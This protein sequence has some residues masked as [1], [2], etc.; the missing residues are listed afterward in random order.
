MV[1][2]ALVVLATGCSD[3][4][5]VAPQACEQ[6]LTT[7]T[8]RACLPADAEVT[9]AGGTAAAARLG[10]FTIELSEAEAGHPDPDQAAFG[11]LAD[12]QGG[13]GRAIRASSP[14][15]AAL[16]PEGPVDVAGTDGAFRSYRAAWDTGEVDHVLSWGRGLTVGDTAGAV[17]VVRQFD[18]DSE[19]SADQ[20]ER[21]E[22]AAL[23]I[24]VTFLPRDDG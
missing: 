18:P 24:V 6:E 16:G 1:A 7:P 10:E 21:A 13:V 8:F 19:V 4:D 2:L 20:A 11:A 14:S 5:S 12:L 9:V 3:G 15:A 17:L 23:P 22:Q